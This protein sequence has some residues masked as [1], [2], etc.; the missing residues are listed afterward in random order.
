MNNILTA[1]KA[2]VKNSSLVVDEDP[3]GVVPN[4][5]NQM[6]AALEDYVKNA[7]ADCLGRDG[8][9]VK[10]A[11][12]RIFSYIG[13]SINP[14]DAMLAGSDAIEIKKIESLGTSQLQLNSSYPKNKLY[15]DNPKICKACRECEA[16]QEKDMV[17]V[18]G[19][20]EGQI[21][22]N[23]FFVYGD[24]YCDSR[25]VYER[26]ENAIKDGLESLDDIKLAETNELGRV[27]NVDHLNISDLR[28]RGMWLIKSPFQHFRSLFEEKTNYTF[29]LVALIP[30]D[31]YNSFQNVE[32]FE[33]FCDE[34]GVVISDEKIED[35]QNPA[36]LINSKLITYFY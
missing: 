29:K 18:V 28:I 25:D 7:F 5:A 32:E 10:L 4:R 26:V 35:P 1:I 11:R 24:L 17:Y 20:V 33:E 12:N 15:S 9:F 21:L 6:G 13:N 8:Q 34:N 2:I 23:I 31:K 22:Q 36:N 3:K 16:W 19:Q 27:N 30:E 14:P